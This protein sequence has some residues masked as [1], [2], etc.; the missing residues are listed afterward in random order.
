[1]GSLFL[2]CPAR[3]ALSGEQDVVLV[4]RPTDLANGVICKFPVSQTTSRADD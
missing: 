1:V 2:T 3:D 4:G